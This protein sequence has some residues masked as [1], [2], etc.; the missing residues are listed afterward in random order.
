LELLLKIVFLFGLECIGDTFC[1][2]LSFWQSLDKTTIAK[3]LAD[4]PAQRDMPTAIP[5]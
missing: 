3:D 1:D 5:M 4:S 2:V